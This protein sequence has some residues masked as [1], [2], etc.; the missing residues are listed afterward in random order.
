MVVSQ[1][2][3][4]YPFLSVRRQ[5]M[6]TLLLLGLVLSGVV[7]PIGLLQGDRTASAAG[8]TTTAALNL[9]ASASLSAGI[10][11]V[12]PSGSGVTVLDGPSAGFYYLDYKG[13]KGWGYGDYLNM[14][15]GGSDGGTSTGP[16]GTAYTTT[17]LNLRSGPSTGD[18][19]LAVMPTGASVNQTG[20][21]SNGFTSVTYSG[22]AGWAYASY[23]SA[24]APVSQPDPEPATGAIIG[25]ATT[26]TGL[27]LRSSASTS[28]SVKVVMPAGAVVD[29]RD[30]KTNGF[31]PVIYNG[32]EGWAYADYLSFGTSGG[33]T[34]Y[35]RDE[36]IAI[37]YSAA[38]YYGQ[39]REAMLRVAKCESNLDPYNVTPPYSA[40]GLF[41]FLPGTWR[42]TPYADKDIF[43]PWASAYAAAWMWSVGRRG[44]WVCQ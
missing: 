9:R 36:I 2:L 38:D 19:V 20:K 34:N 21:S 30:G 15:G 29:V 13:T 44:E 42:T 14:P 31:H 17:S 41:Q 16:T 18:S 27:N 7:G 4:A 10:L 37:I 6:A 8:A 28:S 22:T 35:S 24:G 33:A 32:T 39:S 40:S 26:T 3:G 12:M 23:L 1:P 5:L 25:Q 11:A 43:D